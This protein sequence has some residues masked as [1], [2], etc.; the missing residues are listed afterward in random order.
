M[1]EEID[2][3]EDGIG[4]EATDENRLMYVVKVGKSGDNNI[5]HMLYTDN[6]DNIWMEQW[7][8]KPACNCRNLEPEKSMCSYAKEIRT[9]IEFNLG[10]DSCCHSYQDVCDGVVSIMSEDIDSYEEYPEPFRIVLRFGD[11]MDDVD[12]I[13][14]QRNVVSEFVQR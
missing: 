11:A 9:E 6:I 1:I 3:S 5:Y 13:L 10:Q 7:S 2:F 4:E 14:A 8:E 12:K